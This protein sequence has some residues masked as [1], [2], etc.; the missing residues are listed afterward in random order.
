MIEKDEIPDISK[1][2][3]A[4]REAKGLTQRDLA[5][6]AKVTSP[7]IAFWETGKRFPRGKNL[8]NLAIALGCKESDILDGYDS[9]NPILIK[10]EK[11]KSDLIL[12]IQSRLTTLDES[13]LRAVSSAIDDLPARPSLKP[14]ATST[15]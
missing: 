2:I 7:A 14:K 3:K 9:A 6:L 11:S 15:D 13:E 5:K 4:L 10:N 12:E 8:K 1:R